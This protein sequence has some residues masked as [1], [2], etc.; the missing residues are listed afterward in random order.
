MKGKG[1]QSVS[2]FIALVMVLVIVLSGCTKSKEEGASGD[3]GAADSS[4]GKTADAT[5][6][7]LLKYSYFMGTSDQTYPFMNNPG[8]VITPIVEKKFNIQVSNIDKLP[9]GMTFTDKFNLMLASGDLP[10]VIEAGSKSQL[11]ADSGKYEKLGP[12]IEKYMPNMMKYLPKKDWTSGLYKGELW[13]VPNVQIDTVDPKFDNDPS[14][15]PNADWTLLLREDL[16]QKLGYKFTPLKKV[17]EKANQTGKKPTFE[18]LQIDPPI[19]TPDDLYQFFKKVKALDSSI[20]P[21]DM[22]NYFQG[23]FGTMFGFQYT[24]YW[25]VDTKQVVTGLAAPHAKEFYQYMN[26]LYKEGLIDPDFPVEKEAQLQEKIVAGKVAAYIFAQ[27]NS[28][29]NAAVDK[30]TPGLMYHPIPMPVLAGVTYPGIDPFSLVHSEFYVKKD[31]KD[32]PRLLQYFDWFYSDEALDLAIWG[33]ESL[34]LWVMKDGKKVF[35]DEALH[36]ALADY[37]PNTIADEQ[38]YNKGLGLLPPKFAPSAKAFATAPHF[39]HYV[40]VSWQKSYPFAVTDISTLATTIISTKNLDRNN[41]LLSGGTKV[42]SAAGNWIWGDLYQKVSTT[43]Y[44]AKDD[45]TFNKN[46]DT[47]YKT[48]LDKGQYQEGQKEMAEIAKTFGWGK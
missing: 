40:P 22:P 26:K 12:L 36:Q 19:K 41:V 24:W 47:A 11:I 5:P 10:D 28:A 7:P 21:F 8:D 44:T 43:L 18:E 3:K 29:A 16:L 45:E 15:V 37:K 27:D 39:I 4:A 13:G 17:Q 9:N 30:I 46:W 23:H 35:K 33:P 42:S 38:Y 20:I 25:D 31:F 48:F 14:A 1:F 34:G 6:P 32:I 2:A